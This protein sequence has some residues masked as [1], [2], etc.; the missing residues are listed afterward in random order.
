MPRFA[1]AFLPLVLLAVAQIFA[2]WIDIRPPIPWLVPMLLS[3]ALLPGILVAAL[4]RSRSEG[5]RPSPRARAAADRIAYLGP[6]GGFVLLLATG[7]AGTPPRSIP[8]ELPGLA[9]LLVLLPLFAG[10]SVA[11]A[12]RL[13]GEIRSERI[14]EPVGKTVRREMRPIALIFAAYVLLRA[15]SDVGWLFP[16]LRE[17]LVTDPLLSTAG[18]LVLL[19]SIVIVSPFAVRWLHPARPLA[20]GA[21]RDR[22]DRLAQ[23]AG[24]SL[25]EVWVWDTGPRPAI[26]ACVSG[27]VP[28]HRS[29]FLTDGLLAHLDDT[30]IES[31]FAHELAHGLRH[32][33]WIYAA[34]VLGC[35]GLAV[36]GSELARRAGVDPGA[37]GGIAIL[38][39]TAALFFRFFGVLSRH[40]ESQADI[41]SAERT[42]SPF[43]IVSALGK[44]GALTGTSHRKGWRHPPIPERIA[45]VLSCAADEGRRAAFGRRT[46]LLLAVVA[47]IILLGALGWAGEVAGQ[48]AAPRWERDLSRAAYIIAADA[49]RRE[50]PLAS[51]DRRTRELERAASLVLGALPSLGRDPELRSG[52]YEL[53]AEAYSGLGD[54]PSAAAARYLAGPRREPS[55]WPMRRREIP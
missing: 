48:L 28:A 49:E 43:G 10:W 8:P 41:E 39:A 3:T 51:A 27:V 13:R 9:A 21:L 46:R 47:G 52:A 19:G 20:P 40:F 17:R 1:T 7:W 54:A 24:V 23:E 26:N 11:L 12:S 50:R 18:L 37:G 44:I 25:R 33:L 34:L 14:A 38:V 31:V 29:V 53:L 32:H 36:G 5:S 4:L 15:I 45:T 6:L 55:W 42:G 30:E 16:D 35:G 22:L 2:P